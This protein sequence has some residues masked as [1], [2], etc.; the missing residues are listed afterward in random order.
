M[1]KFDAMKPCSEQGPKPNVGGRGVDA[2]ALESLVQPYKVALAEAQAEIEKMRE[3]L[4]RLAAVIEHQAKE[5]DQLKAKSAR[6]VEALEQIRDSKVWVDV[7]TIAAQAINRM[8]KD[9]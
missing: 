6:L 5:R 9:L 1:I 4:E 3:E 7:R 8:D 2:I